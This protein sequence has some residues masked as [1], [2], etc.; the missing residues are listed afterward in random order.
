MRFNRDDRVKLTQ[1]LD[2]PPDHL[3]R[4][5]A[6]VVT[7]LVPAGNAYWVRFDSLTRDV[8]V[9]DQSLEPE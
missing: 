5:T 9:L 4:G 6:G 2:F 8:M 1:D 7:Q 3:T